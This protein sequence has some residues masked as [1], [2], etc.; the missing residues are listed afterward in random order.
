MSIEQYLKV[1]VVGCGNM[2]RKH[3]INACRTEKVLVV[4]IA[5]I[6]RARTA[7][8]ATEMKATVFNNAEAMLKS[9]PLDAVIIATPPRIRCGVV[10]LAAV[11]GASIFVEKPIALDLPAARRC[12]AAIKNSNLVNAVGFQLRYS[13]LTQR[14]RS[15]ISGL[16]V[17]HVR[18][19][20]TTSYYLNMDMPLWFLQRQESGGPLLEQT[21]HTMDM[22]RYLVG[23]ITHVF[24]RGTRLVRPDL[25]MFDSQDTIVLAY[26]FANGAFG[27]HTDSCAMTN[28]NW[29]IELFGS[30][31]RLLIDYARNRMHGYIGGQTIEEEAHEDLHWLEMQIFLEA[32]RYREPDTVLSDFADATKTLA[33]V[34][35]G[36]RSLKTGVWEPVGEG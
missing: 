24:A 1:G 29:E 32:V 22:A 12:S 26:Q 10:K 19:V 33:T 34:L 3:I 17:T 18:T 35:A 23:D 4:A 30:G 9:V 7:A 13:P 31:W 36:D 8:L 27:T 21:I 5:D 14:A 28:F 2:G 6:D 11:A 15:L 16:T 25:N 20:C